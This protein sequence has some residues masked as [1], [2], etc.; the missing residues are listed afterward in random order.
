VCFLWLCVWVL[1]GLVCCV[2]VCCV[3]GGGLF[4]LLGVCFILR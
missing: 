1:V 2:W 3:F 4:E